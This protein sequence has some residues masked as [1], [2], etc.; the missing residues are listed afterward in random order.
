MPF[1]ITICYVTS[2]DIGFQVQAPWIKKVK[3]N[4]DIVSKFGMILTENDMFS[5]V[6]VTASCSNFVCYTAFAI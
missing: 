6:V 1:F 4:L 3:L 5:L 2:I